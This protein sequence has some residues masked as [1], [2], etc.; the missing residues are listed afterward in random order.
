MPKI[1]LDCRLAMS[2]QQMEQLEAQHFEAP[3]NAEATAM[4][5]V[6]AI[7]AVEQQEVEEVVLNSGELDYL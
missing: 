2:G 1:P 7:N 3:S 5:E 4:Q 6:R